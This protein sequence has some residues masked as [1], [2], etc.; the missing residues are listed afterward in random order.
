M[1]RHA[2]LVDFRYLRSPANKT[3]KKLVHK[4]NFCRN[5]FYMHARPRVMVNK[6]C[7]RQKILMRAMRY[8]PAQASSRRSCD[9]FHSPLFLP[10][11]FVQY[12]MSRE[13][14]LFDGAAAAF[15]PTMKAESKGPPTRWPICGDATKTCVVTCPGDGSQCCN[16]HSM[17]MKRVS[18]GEDFSGI[19]CNCV[20]I[21]PHCDK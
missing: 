8:V 17:D 20:P 16:H 1:S 5:F 18:F 3:G 2:D 12:P 11:G 4:I 15:G 9:C 10:V 21:V 6:S 7:G 13:R 14:F 19:H